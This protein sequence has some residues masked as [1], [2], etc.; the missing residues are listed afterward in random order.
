[1]GLFKSV[2][3][4]FKSV[5][6][7]VK[8]FAIGKKNCEKLGAY[9]ELKKGARCNSAF[10]YLNKGGCSGAKSCC[11]SNPIQSRCNNQIDRNQREPQNQQSNFLI[12][13]YEKLVSYLMNL[14]DNQNTNNEYN[15]YNYNNYNYYNTDNYYNNMFA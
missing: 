8:G 11:N 10:D 5:E 9:K 14:I 2:K 4:A 12:K 13:A 3:K 6:N 1:M 15:Q 7:H